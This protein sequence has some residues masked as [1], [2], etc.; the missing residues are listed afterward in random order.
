MNGR[1][2]FLFFLPFTA[3]QI[4]PFVFWENLW[5]TNLLFSFIWRL[6]PTFLVFA[7]PKI[8]F[9]FLSGL[10]FLVNNEPS[11]LKFL[12]SLEFAKPGTCPEILYFLVFLGLSLNQIWIL[13]VFKFFRFFSIFF[14]VF[15]CQSW[16]L[17][18]V[19]VCKNPENWEVTLSFLSS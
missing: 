16:V 14:E 7:D 12:A 4:R 15:A 10:G 18:K 11:N 6:E 5:L 3:N 9:G 13:I 1:I 17:G 19:R 2:S 8:I